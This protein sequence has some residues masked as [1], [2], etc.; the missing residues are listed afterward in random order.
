[1]KKIILHGEYGE[2]SVRVRV[3]YVDLF[4]LAPSSSTLQR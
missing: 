4:V 3:D 1:M 2:T